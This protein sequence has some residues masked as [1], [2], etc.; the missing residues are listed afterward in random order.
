MESSA[1]NTLGKS[2][3]AKKASVVRGRNCF[4][5]LFFSPSQSA[6]QGQVGIAWS[7]LGGTRHGVLRGISSVMDCRDVAFLGVK[8]KEAAGCGLLTFTPLPWT[9]TA[10]LGAPSS[11]GE[12]PCGAVMV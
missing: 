2:F 5:L 1:S 12:M 3:E 9:T 6:C 10:P 8:A 11:G 7:V 4:S